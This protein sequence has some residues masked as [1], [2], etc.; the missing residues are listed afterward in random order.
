MHT[1]YRHSGLKMFFLS[2]LY[3]KFHI[4]FAVNNVFEILV[5][6][7]MVQISFQWSI[8]LKPSV[9]DAASTEKVHTKRSSAF[10]LM[11]SN[12][13]FEFFLC[14][15][16]FSVSLSTLNHYYIASTAKNKC[17]YHIETDKRQSSRNKN[18][19]NVLNCDNITFFTDSSCTWQKL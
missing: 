14:K 19:S 5:S 15:G 17:Q 4:M 16:D 13:L 7:N 10:Q 9:N 18:Q 11:I 12:D 8:L 3:G 6:T 1:V 2:R